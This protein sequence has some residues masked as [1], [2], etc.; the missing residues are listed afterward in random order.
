[1]HCAAY[2]THTAVE[3]S[4]GN[5]CLLFPISPTHA[6]IHTGTHTQA[7]A[8]THTHISEIIGTS[9]LGDSLRNTAL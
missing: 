1:M 2:L 4:A 5:I 6:Q 8:H 3:L 9:L 7:C